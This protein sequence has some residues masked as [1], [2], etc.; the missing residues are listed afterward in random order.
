M[1]E[2]RAAAEQAA[3]LAGAVIRPLFR[4]ALLVEAKGDASPVTAADQQAEQAIRAFLA[5]RFPDHGIWGEEYGADRPDAEWLWLLDPID[6]TRAFVTGRP[7]FGTLISLLHKGVPVLGL[8]DQPATRERWVGVAGQPTQF[9]GPM[10]GVA[11][12]RPCAVLAEAELSCTSPDMFLEDQRDG[13]DR[14]RRAARR[15]TWGGDCY[16]YGLM[17][18]GLVD[19]VAEAT[20]KP[21]DWAALVPVVQ[22]AGGSVT[23]W[24]GRP[25][26]VESDGSVLA[27]GDPSM[28]AEATALL[29]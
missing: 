22:G 26:T 23:D 15:V 11:K 20:M 10:G 18:L 12:C 28:L 2:Y 5:E 25:L 14:L 9:S 16:S 8:I 27:L 3:D 4:S 17:A 7:L 24:A 6:G 29:R 13:F 21:W 19:V 1:L